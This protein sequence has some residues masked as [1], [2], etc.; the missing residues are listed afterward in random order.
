MNPSGKLLYLD[1]WRG[2]AVAL[3]L[4]GHFFPI[5]GINLGNFGVNLFFVLSGLLMAKVLF[6]DRVTLP[7]FYRRRISRIFPAFLFYILITALLFVCFTHTFHPK[8]FFSALT[9][10]KNY[11]VGNDVEQMPFGHIW[12]LAVEEHSYVILS[13]FALFARTGRFRVIPALWGAIAVMAATCIVYFFATPEAQ[14]YAMVHRTEIAA[15][16]IFVAALF[17]LAPQGLDRYGFLVVPL[18]FMI[19][20]AVQW[21][22]VPFPIRIVI[23]SFALAIC[24]GSLATASQWILT[25]LSFKPLRLLGLWSY[26]IYLWQQPFYLLQSRGLPPL[27]GM[28]LGVACGVAS[29]YAIESPVRNYLNATWGKKRTVA[30]SNEITAGHAASRME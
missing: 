30:V 2:L 17:L 26:S 18:T 8:E 14:I 25:C 6:I 3:L 22:S 16:P 7:V 5:P 20:A 11:F 21:W 9:F 27:L 29:Y 15:L 1:G 4:V 24:V 19:A 28:L 12:S 23:G 13:G 10:T